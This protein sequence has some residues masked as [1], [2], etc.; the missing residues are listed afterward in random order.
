MSRSPASISDDELHDYVDGRLEP[1]A[2]AVVAS[3]IAADPDLATRAAAY[4]AQI[5][6]LH[7]LYDPVLDEP[8]PQRLAATLQ[9]WQPPRR[10]R[11]ARHRLALAASFLLCAILSGSAGWWTN[12]ALQSSSD[13]LEPFVQQAILVHRLSK[14]EAPQEANLI[15]DVI[16]EKD[17]VFP[18]DYLA[19]PFDAP[20]RATT[21]RG[22]SFR[23]V[24]LKTISGA[25]EPAM[26]FLYKDDKD[27][28][29]TL[30]V[31]PT[32]SGMHVPF[33][34]LKKDGYSAL[35][36][37]DGPLVYVLVSQID[38]PNMLTLAR[39]V[40]QSR[41]IGPRAP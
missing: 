37:L 26:Q 16:G 19:A 8:I 4:K 1:T 6:G 11:S 24:A 23:P 25:N 29:V 33:R 41:A 18:V 5:E 9:N 32:K 2:S 7:A 35:F 34:S 12:E 17:E 36:W 39:K 21:L 13:L 30:Y 3:C 31:R 40:Y 15:G 10:A 22:T 20:L 28:I 27:N 38:E 14:T